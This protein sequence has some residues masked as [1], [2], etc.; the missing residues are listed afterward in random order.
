[1]AAKC[2]CNARYSARSVSEVMRGII[3]PSCAAIVLPQFLGIITEPM[4]HCILIV[5]DEPGVVDL[6]AYNLAKHNFDVLSAADGPSAL[7]LARQ[8]KPDLV[9]LDLMLPG[10]HGHDVFRALRRES[11]APV[12]MLTA[13][14]DEFDRV[15]GLE[16][17][18]DDYLSKPFS[19]R[20]LLARV[21]AVLRRGA[22]PP[23]TMNIPAPGLILNSDARTAQIAGHALD[24]TRIEFDLLLLLQRN[25]ERVY[26]REQLLSQ[27]WGYQ[28]FGDAR[29]VDSAIKRLRAKIHAL[30]ATADGIVAVRGIG[31]K[32]SHSQE[33]E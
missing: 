17:G 21:R 10:M 27:I 18:A 26:T 7:Q 9:L 1:M 6:I 15:L 28:F 30:D 29:A 14:G 11:A 12:I 24:L 32:F 19:M 25:A 23:E 16:L 20:E 3:A 5:D 8:H 2:A 13:L 4:S 22:A 33:R 31:Y